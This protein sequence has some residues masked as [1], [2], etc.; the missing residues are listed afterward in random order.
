MTERDS[1]SIVDTFG[2]RGATGIMLA[3]IALAGFC[4]WSLVK[5]QSNHLEHATQ[6]NNQMTQA[7]EKQAIATTELTTFLKARLDR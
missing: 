7:I 5:I 4:V 2:K 1:K 6:A 3:L